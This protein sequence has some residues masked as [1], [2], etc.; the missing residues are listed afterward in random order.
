M[1]SSFLNRNDILYAGLIQSINRGTADILEE[2]RYGVFLRDT[3][4]NAFMVAT[5][6]TEQG[7]QW[8][9]KHEGLNYSLLVLFQKSL[10]D[11]ARKRYGLTSVL[12]CFQ[13]VYKKK[14]PPTLKKN[15]QI[16]VATD[17]DYRIIADNYKSLNLQKKLGLRISDEHLY[18]LF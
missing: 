18:W 8:L 10:V 11:F 14:E 3:V 17:E 1:S 15:I 6:S 5:E 16:Q 13:S 7:I 9:E 12:D 4:S 2:N